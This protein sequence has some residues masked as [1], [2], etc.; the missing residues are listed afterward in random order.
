MFTQLMMA[1]CDGRYQDKCTFENGSVKMAV[2][3][4]SGYAPKSRVAVR[5]SHEGHA[6][7]IGMQILGYPGRSG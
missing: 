4:E 6:A 2:D 1:N 5:S 3:S 7:D